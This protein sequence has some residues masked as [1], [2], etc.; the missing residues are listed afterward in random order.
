M[1]F[2][3][4]RRIFPAE[5]NLFSEVKIMK[6]SIAIRVLPKAKDSDE[7]IRIVDEVIAF[8]EAADLIAM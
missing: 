7:L 1:Y 2:R 4:L 3:R 6:A 8:T 5:A